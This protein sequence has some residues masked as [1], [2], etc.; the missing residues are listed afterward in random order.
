MLSDECSYLFQGD[1]LSS[2]KLYAQSP[3]CPQHF[4]FDG[5]ICDG[6]WYSKYTL[7][8]PLFLAVGKLLN[9]QSLINPIIAALSLLLIFLITKRLFG[10]RAAFISIILSLI[11][12]FFTFMGATYQP[13][14][15]MGFCML[16]F[17]YSIIMGSKEKNWVYPISAG[18][19]LILAINLRPSDGAVLTVSSIPLM[20]GSYLISNN[21]DFLKKSYLVIFLL[22]IVGIGI[23]MSINSVQTGN[24]LLLGFSKYDPGDKWGFG[25]NGHTVFDGLWNLTLSLTRC[26]MWASPFL[27][28]FSIPMLFYKNRIRRSN[29]YPVLSIILLILSYIGFYFGFFSMGFIG[30]ASRYYYLP[31]L[32]I[33]ILASAGIVRSAAV[34]SKRKFFPGNIF[35]SIL[36][37]GCFI[38][39]IFG[40]YLPLTGKIDK[41]YKNAKD[42]ALMV[43]NA[44]TNAE[45]NLILIKSTPNMFSSSYT[46]NNWLYEKQNNLLALYL[47]PEDNKKLIE[48][49][50]E[51]KI[52]IAYWDDRT[53]KFEILPYKDDGVSYADYYYTAINY[54]ALPPAYRDKAPESFKKALELAP[55]RT[56][57]RFNILLNYGMYYYLKSD[58]ER[59][60]ELFQKTT[61]EYP[62]IDSAYFYQ[63]VSLMKLGKTKEATE[64]LNSL[65]NKFPSTQFK[66]KVQN[67]LFSVSHSEPQSPR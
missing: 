67:W 17:I 29:L 15:L 12:P 7:S 65:I 33:L 44:K 13:H 40:V 26:A 22:L 43:E 32:L 19:S 5:I 30:F 53:Q 10:M 50:K 66:D 14:T 61:N 34:L 38:Y 59:S 49:F 64:M 35:I 36:I 48:S 42:R 4:I 58:Y 3:P 21:K 37:I 41:S 20:I 57:D 18:I 51:R 54:S 47:M 27:I 8:W 46:L 55:A 60:Y 11:S 28:L 45:K 25:V 9:I 6:K 24:P 1:L 31:F 63:G 2:G 39:M 56:P 52:F 23:M 62:Q 16:L